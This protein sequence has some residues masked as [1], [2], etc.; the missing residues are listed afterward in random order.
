MGP[1]PEFLRTL[2]YVPRLNED[3]IQACAAAWEADRQR[4]E[5]AEKALQTGRSDA[6]KFVAQVNQVFALA[7]GDSISPKLPDGQLGENG[8]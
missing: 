2:P 4:L 8:V 5:A 1:S 6:A 7:A 3:D